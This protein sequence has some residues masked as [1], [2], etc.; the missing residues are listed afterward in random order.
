MKKI[1]YFK[2]EINYIKDENNKK[3]LITLISLLPN[4]FFKVPASSTGKYHPLFALGDGGLYRH[5]KVVAKIAME[6]LEV[7]D[8]FSDN[9]KDL[10]VMASVM[11]DG[12]KYGLELGDYTRFDHPLICSKVIMEN[13]KKLK[14]DIN[15]LRKLCMMIESHMGKFNKDYHSNIEL[16]LPRNELERFLH[17][18]DYLA[19]RKFLGVCFKEYNVVDF[20]EDKNEKK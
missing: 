3:D 4:Y 1:D 20:K 7:E 14:L 13:H 16:P 15:N 8:R 19:S 18:C 2:D 11:H 6:L 10:I 9:D 12:F 17:R 5:T